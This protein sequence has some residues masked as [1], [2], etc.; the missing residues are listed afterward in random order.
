MQQLTFTKKKVTE[1]PKIRGVETITIF[2]KG[3]LLKLGY[4]AFSVY[5]SKD[6]YLFD[7][8]IN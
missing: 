7:F 2:H 1:K 3:N 5:K 6:T 8:C 4:C